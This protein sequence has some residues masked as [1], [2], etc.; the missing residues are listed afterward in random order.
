MPSRF[1]FLA[2]AVL[3]LPNP[4]ALQGAEAPVRDH[5]ITLEDYFTQSY[6]TACVL[7][8]DGSRVAYTEM[9]WDEDEDARNTDLWVA[10][11]ATGSV[12]RLTFDP[13][14]DT[15]PQ[16]G[17]DGE[18]IYFR[19][20]RK[21]GD[22]EK[23]P[24]NGKAQV[25][26]V[27]AG[28][29]EVQAVTRL[30]GSVREFEIA[31]D[32]RT[33][34]YTKD[35]E[36]VEEDAFESLRKEFKKL[37]YGHGIEEFTELW[38]LD[39]VTWRSRK[40]VDENRVIF[41]FA[42]SPDGHRIAML[43]RPDQNLITNEGWSR[44]DVYDTAT[45]TITSLPD[46]KW[47]EEAPSPYGWIVGPAWSGDGEVLSFRVDFDG[48]PGEVF[49]AHFDQ[50]EEVLI[51]RM[52]RPREVT[53]EGI[54][55]WMPGSRT[56]C[57]TADDHAR[58]RVWG[59]DDIRNGEQGRGRELTPGDVVV[60]LMSFS[61]RKGDLA[62]VMGSPE[63]PHDVFMVKNP[64]SR[65]SFEQVTRINP[66]VETWM[67]PRIS[68]VSWTSDDGTPVEGVLELPPDYEPGD[69]PLP[70]VVA[71][72]GGPTSSDH[73]RFQYWIYG[74]TLFAS[75]GWALLAP[76]YRGSTGYGDKFLTDLIGNKNNLDVMDILAGV[77]SLIERGIADPDRMAVM[78]WS[79]GGYL[80]NC[81]ITRDN[82]FKAASSGAGVFDTAMQWSI[83]D[84]PGHVINYS[85]GLPWNAE[86]KMRA[87]SPLFDADRITT[88]TLIHVGENDA[89]V[90][91]EHS[92]SLYRA[93]RHYVKVPTELIVYPGEGHGLT[94]YSH[95]KAKIS[96]DVKWFNHY[97]LG[98]ADEELE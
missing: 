21:Q 41:A 71:I 12:L 24:A 84:T 45:G 91:Q 44:V 63:H 20:S 68:V 62:V 11:V 4:G 31:R 29:G 74:R 22:G 16:W 57:F 26:R 78:G 48:Y 30:T 56:F 70:L 81:V 18:W 42:V 6:I 95:R 76:N 1:R 93:L 60:E 50:P 3:L 27:P 25:W 15:S 69:G 79:N 53:A 90:P 47:R 40:L 46:R 9:R 39:L 38:A 49:F 83:E 61:D 33:L 64:G 13:A 51:Q 72:H 5:R 92:R 43:T 75:Q 85:E 98:K 34:Y 77:N 86:G 97:V 54:M 66:Q 28:G 73:Y 36:Q 23:P 2:V 59:V 8:P 96:W 65:A 7:S 19:S 52:V 82:R 80:T 67:L 94:K 88:P 55:A 89:R 17:R 58:R 32:G 14:A 87:T 10:E 35:R 37:D